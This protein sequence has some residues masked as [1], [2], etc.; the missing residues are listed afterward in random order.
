MKTYK[1]VVD[2]NGDISWFNES[3]QLHREEG[4]AVEYSD[5]EKRWYRNDKLHRED[6]PAVEMPDGT[7]EWYLNEYFYTESEYNDEINKSTIIDD[8]RILAEKH[9]FTLTPKK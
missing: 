3:N 7:K 2:D 5:G 9:G 1:V 8:L 4:P 6:G